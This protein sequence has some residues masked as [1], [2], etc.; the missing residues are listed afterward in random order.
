[1]KQQENDIMKEKTQL[2]EQLVNAHV[3]HKVNVSKSIKM[4]S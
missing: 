2:V 4:I 3:V 1:M